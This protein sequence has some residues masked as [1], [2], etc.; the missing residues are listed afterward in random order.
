MTM[1]AYEY[2]DVGEELPAPN[3]GKASTARVMQALIKLQAT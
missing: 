3:L 2:W 1:G